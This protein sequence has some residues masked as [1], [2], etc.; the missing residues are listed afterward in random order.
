MTTEAITLR[1]ATTDDVGPM[2]TLLVQ[3]YRTEAP[4]VLRGPVDGQVR[5]FRHLV[6]YELSGGGGGRY[7]AVDTSGT[8]VGSASLR[9]PGRSVEVLLPSGTLQVAVSSIGLSDTLRLILGALRASLISEVNL[10]VGEYYI[11]SV[12][13]DEG[14]RRRGIGAAMVGQIESIAR[15]LG[16]RRALLRVLVVNESARRL[17]L[18]LG[19]RAVSRTPQ[20][21]DWLTF[22]SELMQKDLV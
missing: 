15:S 5:L 12:V 8:I 16:A 7:V 6:E 10:S 13:V 20:I 18:R 3:L 1:P 17:Y 4:G 2:T 11:Y 21:L 19:Y 22:P 14:A 9:S